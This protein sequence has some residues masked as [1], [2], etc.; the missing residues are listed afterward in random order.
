[1]K[2]IRINIQCKRNR[3]TGFLNRYDFAYA[4]RDIVNLDGKVAQQTIKSETSNI[5]NIA[6]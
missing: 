6:Q 4:G 2:R 1:M 3:Q 5:N